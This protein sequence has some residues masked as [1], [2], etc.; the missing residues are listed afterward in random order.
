MKRWQVLTVGV[1]LL[2]IVGFWLAGQVKRV[3]I[4]AAKSS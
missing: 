1:A 2:G 4:A 3:R